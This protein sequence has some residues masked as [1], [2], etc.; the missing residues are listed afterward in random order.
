[1][2]KLQLETSKINLLKS[3]NKISTTD[4]VPEFS[5]IEVCGGPIFGF[6]IPAS[7]SKYK[8]ICLII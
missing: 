4:H 6:F 5:H 1:M 8:K 2:V 3:E 7:I